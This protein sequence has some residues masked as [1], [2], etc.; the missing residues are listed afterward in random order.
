MFLILIPLVAL[1]AFGIALPLNKFVLKKDSTWVEAIPLSTLGP[2]FLDYVRWGGLFVIF[3]W[4][5]LTQVFIY[6]IGLYD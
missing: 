6:F 1:V 2:L 4:P 5:C 3:N